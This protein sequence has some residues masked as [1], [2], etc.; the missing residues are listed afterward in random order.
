MEKHPEPECVIDGQ[1]LEQ[2]QQFKYLRSLLMKDGHN[3]KEVRMRIAM[4]KDAFNKH[5]TL[6]TGKKTRRLKKK[7][8]KKTLVWSLL[9][10]R[11]E[12][13]WRAVKCGFEEEWKNQLERIRYKGIRFEKS[14]HKEKPE[15]HHLEVE[16]EIDRA[17][18]EIQ[19]IVENSHGV[20]RGRRRRR[21]FAEVHTMD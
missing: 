4:A 1:V 5:Q 15:D 21:E 20:K 10:Y 17:Y 11:S 19:R 12:R 13:D 3:E 7:L 9:V 18:Y 16:G 6:L 2:V 8:I 14:K